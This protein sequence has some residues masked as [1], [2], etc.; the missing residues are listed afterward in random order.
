[1]ERAVQRWFESRIELYP[2]ITHRKFSRELIPFLWQC[3]RGLRSLLLAMVVLAG[4]VSAFEVYLLS[5]LGNLIDWMAESGPE[6]FLA[7]QRA[8]LAIL[9]TI[10]AGSL[11]VFAVASWIK[12]QSIQPVFAMRLRWIFHRRILD[13]SLSFF[14]NEFSGRVASTVM[15]TAIAVRDTWFALSDTVVNVIVYFVAVIVVVAG[16]NWHLLISF[17]GWMAIYGAAV[18]Y[19]VP[20]LAKAGADQAGARSAMTGR[21]ADSYTNISTVKLF[22]HADR[23]LHY[24][25]EA[26]EDFMV[27]ARCQSRYISNFQILNH[28]LTILSISSTAAT[29]IRCWMHGI[30]ALGAIA[31]AIAMALRLAA[32]SQW[33]MREFTALFE[34]IGTVRDGIATI[35]HVISVTDHPHAK[36]LHVA[37]G[38]I[39]FEGISFHYDAGRRVIND[40]SL[41]IRPGEKI[42]L[43]GRSGAGSL[44]WST[45]Y[46]AFMLCKPGVFSL[47]VRILR[48]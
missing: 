24:A 16:F 28:C 35:A 3:T 29:A 45:S 21:V 10:L 27:T 18:V 43:V 37:S 41:T 26:M 20:R 15:Q 48:S 25:R 13:Q 46:Y 31:A 2:Q 7:E 44:R 42:G 14:H 36:S 38:E 32:V 6:K 23:E 47:M 33:I 40:L 17:I 11:A 8:R 12:F 34:N 39:R 5:M 22:A 4:M 9:V 30:L 19:F 1:M